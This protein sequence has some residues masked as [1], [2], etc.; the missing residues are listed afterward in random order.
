[1]K[2]LTN[3]LIGI[4]IGGTSMELAKWVN[5]EGYVWWGIGTLTGL[6]LAWIQAGRAALEAEKER[7]T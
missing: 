5:G 3:A 1:M 7:G 2:F 4:V 6:L